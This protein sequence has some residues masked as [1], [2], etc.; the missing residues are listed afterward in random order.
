[1]AFKFKAA[2]F[3][4]DDTLFDWKAKRFIPS[5]LE[6]VK[7]LQKEGVKIFVSTARCYASAK[8]FGVFDLGI[9]WDGHSTF[10]GGVVYAG[11]ELIFC[12]RI[13]PS[14]VYRLI[15]VVKSFG[16]NMEIIGPK[17]RAMIG[18]RDEWTNQYYAHFAD[19]VSMIRK[20][21]GG[22]V[23]GVLLYTPEE[24]DT[25]INEKIPELVLRRFAPFGCDASA[26]P[27]RDKAQGIEKLLEHFGIEKK[28]AIAFGDSNPDMDMKKAVGT[29]VIVGN[30][31]EEAKAV[32]DYVCEPIEENGIVKT[33]LKYGLEM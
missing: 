18:K 14:V 24:K 32:A 7:A 12:D 5:G 2:F 27:N 8:E 1:M 28:D 30:G 23:P 15:D 16:G 10:S 4:I 3:D 6:A 19:P 11:H 25:I 33:L 22:L 9:K 20:Y 31:K 13:K 29:L 26:N 21:K 17:T